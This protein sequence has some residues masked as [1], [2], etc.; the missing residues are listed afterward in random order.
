MRHFYILFFLTLFI[1]SCDPLGSRDRVSSEFD[2]EI[3]GAFSMSVH[4]SASHGIFTPSENMGVIMQLQ[5]DND[6]ILLISF[7]GL[8]EIF[9]ELE[10]YVIVEY[11][12]NGLF[13]DMSEGQFHVLLTQETFDNFSPEFTSEIGSITI[14]DYTDTVIEG[15]FEFDAAGYEYTAN[16]ED[17]TV[18]VN[19]SV[20]GNFKSVRGELL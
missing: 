7:T 16:G 4:G 2:M 18:R 13:G 9:P 12:T 14:T 15:M 5:S 3:S 20:S 11:T 17:D 8:S 10:S 19:I 1:T 6:S